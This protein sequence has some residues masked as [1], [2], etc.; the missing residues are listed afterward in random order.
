MKLHWKHSTVAALMTL[1]VTGAAAAQAP[2]GHT[3]HVF[4]RGAEAGSEEVTVFGSPDGW[5]L[6]GSGRLGAPL[7]LTTEYWEI[8]YDKTWR[9]IDLTVN[10]ADKTNR[11][12]VHST[13]SGVNAAND[14]T[15]NG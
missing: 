1:V 10:Q 14:V 13:F 11:W 12:T 4:I 8:R 3:F 5:V 7:N 15:Q 9:P 6:R 2:A